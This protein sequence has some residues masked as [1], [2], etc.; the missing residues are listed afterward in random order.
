MTTNPDFNDTPL[1]YVEY[2]STITF[3]EE[4]TTLSAPCS[5]LTRKWYKTELYL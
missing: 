1:L 5:T 3:I 4:C 2:F